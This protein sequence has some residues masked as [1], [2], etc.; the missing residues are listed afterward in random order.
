[1]GAQDVMGQ[2][3]KRDTAAARDIEEVVVVAY[4]RQKK[5][6]LTGANVQVT[7]AQ[8]ADRPVSNVM[9]ALDGAGAGIQ[10]ASGSGQPGSGL[11]IRIRGTGS[12]LVTNEP[13]IVLD[14][15][16]FNGS[17]SSI[18]PNDVE[19][20][21]VLK[22]ASA[23][24]LYGS[25]AANGVI[26]ITTKRGKKGADR[27]SLNST[28]GVVSRFVNEYDR[29]MDPAQ[30]YVL[31]WEAM[32]NGRRES[33][34]AEGLAASNAWASNNLIGGNLKVNVFNVPDNQLVVDGVFNPNAKLKY[35]DFDWVAPIVNTG[36]RQE[37]TLSYSGGNE[38]STFY[39]SLGYTKEEG[40][41][42]KSDFERLA[43]RLNSDTQVRE[44][45]KIGSSLNGSM[46]YTNNAVDGASNNAAYINPYR[47]TRGMGPIYSP[48]LRDPATGQRLYDQYGNVLYDGGTRGAD[49]AS[50]RNIIWETLLNDSSSKVH[51]AQA[52]LYADFQL[53]P[54]LSLRTNVAYAYTGTLNKAYTNR[55]IG[56]AIGAGSSTR[57]S[58]NYQD[59][60][61]NQILTYNKDFDL[62]GI[63]VT[64]GHENNRYNYDYL[65]GYKRD[66]IVNDITDFENFVTNSSM[67][68][69]YN[70]RTKEGYFGRV[71]YNYDEK[72]LLEGS[73]RRDGSSRFASDVRWKNFWSAGAGWVISR[74]NFLQGNSTLNFLK[75][76][77]SYG[78][79][80]ND[81]L[82]SWYAF[83]SL[84][85]LGYNNGSEP[86]IL[87]GSKADATITWETKAQMD[88][89]LE[90]QMFNNRV[91]GTFEYFNS[92]TRD[93]LFPL[94]QPLNAG[95]PGNSIDSNI[96]NIVNKG[97]EVT[98]GFD[99]IRSPDFGWKLDLFGT[100]Y[101]N[102]I[103]K[104]PT[105]EI[106]NGTKKLMVGKDLYSFWLRDWYGVDPA[107]GSALF[108][109]D[110]T[111]YPDTSAADVRNING[112]LVTTNQ[113]KANYSYHGS[114]IPDV[115]GN[116]S[117]T[118][119]VK[120]WELSAAFNYQFGG[121]IYDSNYASL[122][123]GFPQGGALHADMMNRWTTPGQ[124][125]DVPRL[126]SNTTAASGAASSRWLVDASYVMLRNATLG[127]TVN[128]EMINSLGLNSLKLFVSGENLWLQSK[129]KGLEPYQSF[130]GTVSNRY[131][132]SRI[133][134]FGLSTNF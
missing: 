92:E 113:N 88:A 73:I 131:T 121:K 9:Q 124:V 94:P 28:T 99:I 133:I 80:G 118:L 109:L 49:A 85:T 101:K 59:L 66:Q 34:P 132:P 127:Y 52:N 91:R 3:T 5:S 77:G 102:E 134:T 123:T 20:F 51:N 32:R 16:P 111:L 12:Y 1:M 129:R 43:L 117:T 35:N 97:V 122:M 78:E 115:F 33:N 57:S 54:E 83:R 105:K 44:W 70:I 26:L 41:I 40:Y 6:T 114:A 72:Y 64:A 42:I 25:A 45:L 47:W 11:S 50:G 38:K 74:E 27:I 125:T 18:N 86:G 79:V 89:A 63:A 69:S 22:D 68:S 87:F 62:H 120:N 19:S 8:I 17:I 46:R 7:A 100:H 10:V 128:R 23:T 126:S 48:Y 30:Y 112:T 116:V 24:S 14:G 36:I 37:H 71:N 15:V 108:V 90:F 31:A 98:L 103:T 4:G 106:I 104:L 119:R 2:R 39:S 55:V 60:T 84:F 93:L 107:D 53:L 110:Q 95:I 65:Y 96:G 56:D 61:W 29:I 58:Y 21:N 82:D 76:R 13:L 81:A 75:L 130:N 67:T